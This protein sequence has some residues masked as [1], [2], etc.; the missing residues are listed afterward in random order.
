MTYSA[1]GLIQASDYNSFVSSINT[2]WGTG[3]G[4]SGYGQSSTLSNATASVNIAST[5]WAAAVSRV[6]SM[7]NHQSGVSYTPTDGTPASGG[8]IK[9]LTDFN[10]TITTIQTNK[11][12]ANANGSDTT[13]NLDY[14]TTTGGGW[15][16]SYVREASVTFASGDAARYFFNAGGKIIVSYS[17]SSPDN[18]KSTDWQTLCSNAGSFIFGA[19]TSSKSGGGGNTPS[20]YLTTSGYYNLTTSYAAWFKQFSTGSSA[21]YY[22]NNYIQ[23]EVK[24]NGVQGS[25]ADVGSVLTF[26]ASFVDAATDSTYPELAGTPD[27]VDEVH[28][29]LRVSITV[30]PPSSTYLTT[31]SW[32]TP[33]VASVSSTGTGSS[34]AQTVATRSFVNNYSTSP[35]NLDSNGAFVVNGSSAPYL[36]PSF[37][38]RAW[39]YLWGAGG[40]GGTNG[41]ANYA[42]G[43]PGGFT[44]GLM[45]FKAGYTY[46]LRAGEQ[47]RWAYGTGYYPAGGGG[48]GDNGGSGG[49]YTAIFLN[50]EGFGGAIMVAGAGGGGG[51]SWE[52]GGGS[53]VPGGGGGG[54]GSSGQAAGRNPWGTAAQGGTQVNAGATNNGAYQG[55]NG[56]WNG[57]NMQ[58]GASGGGGGGGGGYYGGGGGGSSVGGNWYFPGGGGSGYYNSTH[59]SSAATFT[60]TGGGCC[61]GGDTFRYAA[62]YTNG[63]NA[64]YG[65]G[66]YMVSDGAPGRLVIL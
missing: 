3:S 39:V 25:N 33:S 47:G 35:W 13:T 59:V 26:K 21:S 60:A 7:R 50:A 51:N 53:A 66:G 42:P 28:G 31:A 23:L 8:L 2:L 37:D 19:T 29:T 32:G 18:S 14:T 54:G 55:Y 38:F 56:A 16:T 36:Q 46:Y 65:A 20:P 24:S 63:Y 57:Y 22:A 9:Y 41:G 48:R 49:G 17:L 34:S 11:L 27:Y 64:G 30:R 62:G 52:M 5:E 1:G 4:Q 58:G 40:G 44:Y 6:N 61:G 45:Q 15:T 10:S 43:G 12:V